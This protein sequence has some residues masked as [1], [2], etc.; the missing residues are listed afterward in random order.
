MATSEQSRTRAAV[1]LGSAALALVLLFAGRRGGAGGGGGSDRGPGLADA[2]AAPLPAVPLTPKE[3]QVWLRSGDR[4]ELDGAAADLATTIARARAAGRAHVRATGDVRTGWI[5]T[6]I[7]AMRSA[8]VTVLADASLLDD[9]ANVQAR[10]DGLDLGVRNAARRRGSLP[11]YDER[12]GLWCG[13]D[14]RTL[15]AFTSRQTGRTWVAPGANVM[16]W[17]PGATVRVAT[18]DEAEA[19]WQRPLHPG[20][21]VG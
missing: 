12:R 6:V 17:G 3:V 21:L 20:W 1:V 7:N 16:Y 14:A 5:G 11:Y 13:G 19:L 2:G 15:Y 9:A 10:A 4:I 8:N 18:R